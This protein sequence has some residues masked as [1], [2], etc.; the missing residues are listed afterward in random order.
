MG[1]T[2]EQVVSDI[3][4]N[5]KSGL[6]KRVEHLEGAGYV[7]AERCEKTH[8]DIA[9]RVDDINKEIPRLLSAVRDEL[10][11]DIKSVSRK[12]DLYALLQIIVVVGAVIGLFI[13]GV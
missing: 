12:N 2:L 8:R 3:Y 1:A 9:E 6:F 5:G 11:S 7:S 4:G 13:R 10:R